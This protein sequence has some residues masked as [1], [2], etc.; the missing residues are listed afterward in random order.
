MSKYED[1]PTEC[2]MSVVIQVVLY[3]K[4][5]SE[6]NICRELGSSGGAQLPYKLRRGD[7]PSHPRTSTSVTQAPGRLVG[8]D[9][10]S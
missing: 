5:N 4:T 9:V 10:G 7:T 6:R 3:K 1:Q 8:L 2:K